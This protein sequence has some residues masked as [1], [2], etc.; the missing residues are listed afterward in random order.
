MSD[1]IYCFVG[2]KSA[3][4]ILP[5]LNLAQKCHENDT[6]TIYISN[7]TNLDHHLVRNASGVDEQYVYRTEGSSSF[8][9]LRFLQQLFHCSITCIRSLRLLQRTFPDRVIATGGVLSVPVC[10]AAWLL[11]IP[12]E[13]YECNAVAGKAVYY[14][15]YIA[16][17]VNICFSHARNTLSSR[18]HV[19][20]VGYP[21]AP[22]MREPISRE[23]ARAQL[24]VSECS[25]VI[26]VLGGSQGSL[27][28][29]RLLGQVVQHLTRGTYM[30][31]HQTGYQNPNE[32]FELYRTYGIKAEVFRFR[33][34]IHLLYYA[35]DFCIARAGAGTLFEL[36]ACGTPSLL[37]PLPEHITAHQYDNAC[38]M[39]T[40]YP[41]Q[42]QMV[43]Q[44]AV[45]PL[46]VACTIMRKYD[47][48]SV[49][50]HT[51]PADDAVQS[52]HQLSR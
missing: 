2:G 7:D 33:S 31:F 29:N 41:C 18:A 4:H 21:L 8:R 46:D 27:F 14:V 43:T 36:H 26:L 20:E 10:Y 34:D 38:A 24:G 1:R 15:S 16:D 9:V 28:V 48:M 3:G 12:V 47:Q 45:A 23:A 13:V 50:T 51:M 32:M 22:H 44:D 5:A 37:I 30:I 25:C 11:H 17:R 42:F 6:Y 40:A 39:V 49:H 19:E 35:A 52:D